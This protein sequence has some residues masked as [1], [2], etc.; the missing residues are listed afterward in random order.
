MYFVN[1]PSHVLSLYLVTGLLQILSA[2][3]ISQ[4]VML[5]KI[6]ISFTCRENRHL[7]EDQILESVVNFA[8]RFKNYSFVN[9]EICNYDAVS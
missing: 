3:V 4:S 6:V 1:A 9:S 2:M 8:K 7:H 5:M